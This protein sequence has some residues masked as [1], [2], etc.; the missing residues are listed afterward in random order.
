MNYSY[1]R[2]VKME[3][4][5]L[6][7]SS[8]NCSTSY[9]FKIYKSESLETTLLYYRQAPSHIILVHAITIW[10]LHFCHLLSCWLWHQCLH[11]KSRAILENQ[12]LVPSCKCWTRISN[13]SHGRRIGKAV[14]CP[15]IVKFSLWYWWII[16]EGTFSFYSFEGQLQFYRMDGVTF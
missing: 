1:K 15:N 9:T 11:Q 8:I 10:G 6:Q 14:Y 7:S 16:V 5:V 4:K 13:P 12:F 2:R 3:S